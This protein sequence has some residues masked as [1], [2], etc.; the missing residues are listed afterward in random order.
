ME[1]VYCIKY[2]CLYRQTESRGGR[3]DCNSSR[4][5]LQA[6]HFLHNS[7]FNTITDKKRIYFT[8]ILNTVKCG[9]KKD[10]GVNSS[11]R[12]VVDEN[13]ALLG[14]YTASSGNF[15]PT[16]RDNFSVRNYHYSL[17]NNPE[18]SSSKDTCK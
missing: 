10:V 6:F 11:C 2:G 9:I 17:C 15:L 3:N 16:F 7:I 4:L 14:C 1:T 8:L 18:E 5:S 12:H 13:Y